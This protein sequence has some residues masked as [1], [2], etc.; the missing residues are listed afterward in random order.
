MIVLRGL[1]T[2]LVIFWV[3]S[4]SAQVLDNV[5]IR[6]QISD[7]GNDDTCKVAYHFGSKQYIKDEALYLANDGFYHFEEDSVPPGIYLFVF[8]DGNYFEFLLNEQ[9]F[10]LYTSK[11]NAVT[12]M[13]VSDSKENQVF[14]DYL[15]FLNNRRGLQQKLAPEGREPSPEAKAQLDALTGEVLAYQKRIVQENDNM[16]VARIIKANIE[17]EY[18]SN[19]PEGL[20]DKDAQTFRYIQYRRHFFDNV[21]FSTEHLLYSPI[22]SQKIEYY[23]EKL[24]YQEPDS[25]IVAVE[26]IIKLVEAGNNEQVFKVVVVELVNRYAKS[27]RICHDK[28]YVHIVEKYYNTGKAVWADETQIAKMKSRAEVLNNVLCGKKAPI[29]NLPTFREQSFFL[30]G[31]KAQNTIIIFYQPDCEHCKTTTTALKELY[32]SMSNE[33]TVIAVYI[34]SDY[35]EWVEHI[36]EFRIGDWIN[37]YN[38]RNKYDFAELYDIRNTPQIYVLDENLIIRFKRVGVE[39]IPALIKAD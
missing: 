12:D 11:E 18:S 9:N 21:D 8:P 37:V 19:A 14:F 22:V 15:K 4:T 34:G 36:K 25:Q 7:L 33:M 27:K 38:A 23:L 39:S 30:A 16:L 2:T 3:A 32:D 24:T 29:F 20:S 5:H 31:H 10:T 35:E 28:I 13:L 26:R 17:P 1:W 6:F